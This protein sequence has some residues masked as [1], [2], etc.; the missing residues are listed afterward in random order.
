MRAKPRSS[1]SAIE[2]ALYPYQSF[3][4]FFHFV[5]TSILILP[6]GAASVWTDNNTVSHG[7]ILPNP[8][9]RT[10]LGVQVVYRHVEETLD[11]TCVQI[12]GDDVVA[13]SGLQHVGHEL[14]CDGRT[15]LVLLVLARIGEV[16][17]DGGDTTGA[18]GL[19]GV[20]HDE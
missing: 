19:A 8:S 11:L 2:V 13:A 12:H 16:G 15:A 6:L 14:S 18:G 7:Q 20:D 10:W 17:E 9:Q 3:V 1:P 5:L 4:P